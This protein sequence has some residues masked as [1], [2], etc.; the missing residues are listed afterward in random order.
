[1]EYVSIRL[2]VNTCSNMIHSLTHVYSLVHIFII[3][4]VFNYSVFTV[5]GG[6]SLDFTYKNVVCQ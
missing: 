6:E 1:M 4:L 5:K 3:V 2:K